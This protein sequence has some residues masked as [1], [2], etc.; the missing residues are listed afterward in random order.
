MKTDSQEE[1]R[2]LQSRCGD[3]IDLRQPLKPRIDILD[4]GYEYTFITGQKQ[5]KIT[6]R[7]L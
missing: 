5:P 4:A 7:T 2:D 3:L 1:M 6:R